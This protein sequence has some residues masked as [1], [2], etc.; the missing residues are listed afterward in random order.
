MIRILAFTPTYGN[1]PLAETIASVAAQVF[2]GELVSE[3][4]WHNPFPGADM[5]N[6]TAQYQR[7]RELTLDGRYDALLCVEH[8]MVIPLHAAQTLWDDGAAVVYGVYRL[9]HTSHVLNAWM[10]NGRRLGK[11]MSF[12]PEKITE[13]RKAKRIEV[14]GLGFGCTLIRRH[15]LEQVRIR[16]EDDNAPDTPF[17]KDCLR[18]GIQSYA[19]FDVPCLHIEN[20]I[21]LEPFTEDG[22]ACRVYALRDGTLDLNGKPYIVERDRYYTVLPSVAAVWADAGHVRITAGMYAP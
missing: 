5:R 4:S 2:D 20:G 17:A 15:V 3:V 18:K 1:G 10:T 12:Y 9:R 16:N 11:Q 13:A 6:V 14:A 7:A 8:D 22:I 19:R 21:R